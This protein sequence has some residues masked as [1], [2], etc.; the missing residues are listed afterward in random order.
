M[1]VIARNRRPRSVLCAALLTIALSLFLGAGEVFAASPVGVPHVA[2]G[3]VAA[4]AP[5]KQA[6]ATVKSAV[7]KAATATRPVTHPVA[8]AASPVGTQASAAVQ[9][10]VRS[11][12]PPTAAV[13][14]H[15][16]AAHT[17]T[18]K[19]RR[20]APRA[21]ASGTHGAA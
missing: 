15:A 16:A 12:Q 18:S 11:A 7:D 4:A 13:R 9:P 3:T 8:A 10:V 19:S 5:A 2:Q 1:S 17:H 21:G 20:E 14:S 6:V